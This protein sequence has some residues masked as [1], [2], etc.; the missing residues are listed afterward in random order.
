MADGSLTFAADAQPQTV[1]MLR[2]EQPADADY[3]TKYTY[4]A[5]VPAQ[6]VAQ[7]TNLCLMAQNGQL[8]NT[9]ALTAALDL[10]AS[11]AKR[12]TATL[13]AT[14]IQTVFIP[15]GTFL[16]GSSDGTNIGDAAGTGLNTTPAEP[17]RYDDETQHSVTLTKDFYM[18]KYAVTFAQ[19]KAYCTAKGLTPPSNSGWEGD[20]RPVINVSWDDAVAYCTWLSEQTGQTWRLPTEAQWEYACRAGTTTPFSLGTAGDGNSFV[21]TQGN[22]WW[23]APYDV[24]QNGHYAD[25]SQTPL[26]KTQP[27]GSYAPN[28][29]GL[30][31][32]HGNVFEWCLDG[33]RTYTGDPITDPLGSTTPGAGRV[34]R[35]CGWSGSAQDCRSAFRYYGYPVLANNL[36]GFRVVLV[37]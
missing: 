11:A 9:P 6:A 26:V 36:I 5:L 25:N 37:P 33:L 2:V 10:T 15:K 3:A 14:A 29:W 28:A 16:M 17:N 22:F 23:S 19:Y 30:Y 18:S 34:V 27:V 4:R 24:A 31:D 35:G 1:K 7:G 20:D 13:P 8:Y 12:Y 21:S 32:M